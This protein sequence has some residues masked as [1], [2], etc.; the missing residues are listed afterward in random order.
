MNQWVSDGL[1]RSELDPDLPGPRPVKLAEEDRLPRSE[2]KLSLVDEDRRGVP[3][4]YRLQVGVHVPIVVLVSGIPREEST[5]VSHDIPPDCRIVS[6][7]NRDR[8][9]RMRNI[10]RTDLVAHPLRV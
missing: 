7:L 9:G 6:F 1:A 2:A 10:D 3:H 4:Q 5:Q 8:C